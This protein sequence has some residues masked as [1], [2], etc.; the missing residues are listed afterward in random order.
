M[1]NA[2]VKDSPSAKLKTEQFLSDLV[3]HTKYA[4]YVPE[5]MRRQNWGEAMMKL[6]TM[7]TDKFPNLADEIYNNFKMAHDKKVLPSMRS[8]QYGGIPIEL[9]PAR[10][11]NCSYGVVDHPFFFA[12]AMFLLLAGSGVGYS[13]RK[14][15]VKRLPKVVKPDGERRFLIGDSI[16]GWADSFR[17][18]IYAYLRANPR[19]RFDYR[20]IRPKGAPIKKSGGTAPGHESLQLAHERVEA[21]LKQATGRRLSPLECS[22]ILNY[23]ADCVLAGGKRD[24]AM[25]GLFDVDDV[26]MASSKGSYKVKNGKII[27]TKRDGWLVECEL[28]E[29]QVMDINCYNGTNIQQFFITNQFGDWDLVNMLQNGDLPFYYLHPQR[30]RSNIS[31]AIKRGS[32]TKEKF[33]ELWQV[34]KDTKSGEPGTYWFNDND[35][36]TNPCA[37]IALLPFSFCNLTSINVFDVDNQQELNARA[38]VAAFIGTLQASYTDFHYLRPIWKDTTEK[39]ALLGV[40]MTGIASGKVLNLDLSEAAKIVVDENQRVAKIIGINQAARTTCIKPEGSG[41]LAAGIQ[42][43][44]IHAIHD[45]YYIRNN[46]IKKKDPTYSFLLE[47][48]PAFIE[49]EFKYETL[50]AVVSIPMRAPHGA[51]TRKSETAI[52]LLERIKRFHK[53]WIL[54]GHRHGIGT[55][56]VSATVNLRDN[57]WDEVAEWLWENRNDYCGLAIYPFSDAIYKQAPFQSITEKEYEAM[58]AAFPDEVDFST[59]VENTDNVQISDNLACAGGACLV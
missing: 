15:H 14:H 50:S 49:D 21:V 43:N 57:E 41:T 3:I 28:I 44:G 10:I 11:F 9:N 58:F 13:V 42:G 27:E 33:M 31:R 1:T 17:Q 8:I 52:D 22:D 19:P 51:I 5:H 39:E 16:E 45:D 32:I 24:A 46:R 4:N 29:N 18:L 34:T 25:I 37:E 12:E 47:H 40:S 20:D 36:G 2:I 48:A 7:H 6:Q 54:P 55:H 23:A 59:L 56:N 30:G 35:S 53:E 26:D 38:K